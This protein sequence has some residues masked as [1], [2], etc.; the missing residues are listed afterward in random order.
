VSTQPLELDVPVIP[1][2]DTHPAI[3]RTF[4]GLASGESMVI[5]DDH[6]P[7]PLRHQLLAER[8]DTF[9]CTGRSE[10]TVRE[11]AG[12]A[13]EQA[14][15][16]GRAE[17]AA[18]FLRDPMLPDAQRV[19]PPIDETADHWSPDVEEPVH[20]PRTHREIARHD[21]R[22][23]PTPPTG[24]GCSF[25][26]CPPPSAASSR[27]SPARCCSSSPSPSPASPARRRRWPRRRVPVRSR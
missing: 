26:A 18:C 1:P 6:D 17:L 3:L 16:A 21:V 22:V 4:D 19:V 8:P 25:P 2:S 24:A 23:S 12:V 27:S 15:L 13:Y 11:H 14:G 9:G 7:R 20:S 5:V 10:H